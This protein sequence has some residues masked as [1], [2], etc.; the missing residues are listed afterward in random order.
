[1]L[2]FLACG[3]KPVSLDPL[4]GGTYMETVWFILG[5][6]GAGK[7]HFSSY[8]S[9]H[10]SFVHFEIDQTP[11]DGIDHFGFRAEW[12]HYFATGDVS[13]L[14]S[15]IRRRFC[16][17]CQGA[18]LSFPSNLVACLNAQHA[19]GLDD[20]VKLV[21]LSGTPEAC[22]R[23][24]WEREGQM[25]RSLP[26]DHW[27]RNNLHLYPALERPWLTP[28]VINVFTTSGA[29]RT[30]GEILTEALAAV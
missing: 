23:S 11:H 17:A 21:V 28:S 24:F 26:P 22:R 10:L 4:D 19:A 27:E 29:R 2:N 12:N 14:H 8:V 7:S 1:M 20:T 15:E 3:A 9:D 25:A 16:G 6:S 18:V 30:T 13:L 5:I